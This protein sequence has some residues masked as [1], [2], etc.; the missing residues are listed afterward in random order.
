[1][2]KLICLIWVMTTVFTLSVSV[3]AGDVPEA[4]SYE[5]N[6]Q[7]FIGTLKGFSPD[8]S[9]G[10]KIH[11]VL[12]LPTIKIKGDVPI[13][14]L[15]TYELCYFGKVT[16]KTEKEYLFG[17]LGNNSVWVY[18]IESHTENKIKLE[19]TDAF[20]ERIQNY[21]DEGVYAREEQERSTL[22]AQ[23]SFAEF[24]YKTPSPTKPEAEKVILRYKNELYPVDKD[25]FFKIAEDIMITNVKNEPLHDAA[26]KPK[27]PDPYTTTLYVEVFD[28]KNHLTYYGAVSRFGEVD[29]HSLFMSRLMTKDYKMEKEDLVRLY[30]LLPADIQKEIKT[31][32]GYP[33]DKPLALSEESQKNHIGFIIVLAVAVFAVA[34]VIGFSI[35]N[36]KQK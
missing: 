31:P 26:A 8:N 24:L 5:D 18:G 10:S 20:A 25:K 3:F 6:A 12:V 2:K 22:G 4:L 29:R 19:I 33:A 28:A 32:E 16:P 35:Y 36:K 13:N 7:V 9:E 17:W 23:I 14:E 34:F 11:N 1:M 30:S 21:L 27:Q 15:Q